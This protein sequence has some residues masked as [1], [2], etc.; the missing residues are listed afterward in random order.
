MLNFHKVQFLFIELQF[1]EQIRFSGQFQMNFGRA[2]NSYFVTSM[3]L[4]GNWDFRDQKNRRALRVI[5]RIS[6]QHNSYLLGTGWYFIPQYTSIILDWHWSVSTR[7]VQG[8]CL[9][10]E[11]SAP[12][13]RLQFLFNDGKIRIF[14]SKHLYFCDF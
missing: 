10:L 7:L 12:V 14:Y 9:D 11:F 8:V 4:S 13:Y 2:G 1:T 5:L 6:N 3:Y